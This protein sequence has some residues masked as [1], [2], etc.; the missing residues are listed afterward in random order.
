[1]VTETMGCSWEQIDSDT[2][3]ICNYHLHTIQSALWPPW[4]QENLN[5]GAEHVFH[6]SRP[7]LHFGIYTRL[8]NL[9]TNEIGKG[10]V[11]PKKQPSIPA[12]I[13][14]G[15]TRL[16][17]LL[18]AKVRAI[19]LYFEYSGPLFTQ[20]FLSSN[21]SNDLRSGCEGPTKSFCLCWPLAVPLW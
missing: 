17:F 15:N 5:C 1:M 3:R 7:S 2:R 12:L 16:G 14:N 9:F 6:T 19:P 11:R 10:R 18:F 21:H 13:P 4:L 20:T 8:C